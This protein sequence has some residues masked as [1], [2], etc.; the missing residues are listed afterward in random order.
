MPAAIMAVGWVV[1]LL[2]ALWLPSA[3]L[4]HQAPPKGGRHQAHTGDQI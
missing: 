1:A 2:V 4:L 3:T